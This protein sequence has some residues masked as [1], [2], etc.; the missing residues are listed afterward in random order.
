MKPGV[1]VWIP[2]V[3]T[4]LVVL[5]VVGFLGFGL[6]GDR[7]AA[8]ATAT[9][10]ASGTQTAVAGVDATR[11]AVA[12]PIDCGQV[13]VSPGVAPAAAALDSAGCFQFAFE[14]CRPAQIAL[15]NTD[16]GTTRTFATGKQGTRCYIVLT[17]Q[18]SD[19]SKGPV[20]APIQCLGE[21]LQTDG[22][23]ISGCGG[24][25]DILIPAAQP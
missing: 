19:P 22:L 4:A 17:T 5:L 21:A 11:T 16:S 15:L 24:Q 14:S 12:G 9:S 1:P 6:I 20:P 18:F 7:R 10:Q 23:H 3:V 8:N 25:E 13:R 2:I